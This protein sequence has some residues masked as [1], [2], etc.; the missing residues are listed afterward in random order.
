MAEIEKRIPGDAPDQQTDQWPEEWMGEPDSE[1]MACLWE[2]EDRAYRI[3]ILGTGPGFMAI[4]DIAH[5]PIFRTY[6]PDLEVAAVAEPGPNRSKL[7]YA[8]SQGLP[9]YAHLSEML[10]EHRDINLL[11]DLTGHRHRLRL[12]REELPYSVSFIDQDAAIFLCGLHDMAKSTGY[13]RDSLDRQRHLLQ[14]IIDEVREDILLLDMQGRVVDMNR[15]VWER[16]GRPKEEL[17]GKVCHE[18][19]TLPDGELLCPGGEESCPRFACIASGRKEEQLITRVSE[20]G[21]LLY[22]RVYAYPIYNQTGK[23]THV[24]IMH[25]DITARTMREK[26]QQQTDKLAVVGEMSTYLA[27][28]IRNPLMAIGGF[29]QS[30]MKSQ[31]LTDREREKLSIIA[32]ETRRLDNLLTGILNFV[33]PSRAPAGA[34]D[35]AKLVDE[36]VDLMK[37]GYA[38]QGYTFDVSVEPELPKVKG[39]EE[40]VKQCLVNMIKN[41]MEAMEEGG[42]VKV[43][44]GL[45]HDLVYL[46]VE[47]SGVGMT[48]ADMDKVFSPFYS[49][50]DKGY[51]LGLAMMKK[52]VEDLGGH[53]DLTSKLGEGT[54]VTI[55]LP[56]LLAGEEGQ[57]MPEVDAAGIGSEQEHG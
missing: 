38:K 54:T 19:L 17:V 57:A 27:H 21:R 22:F 40:M 41:S 52:I 56:P 16:T 53:I 26:H 33:R 12:L 4:M 36:T 39:G 18:V 2:G 45:E 34:V 43:S 11:I 51:G 32:D 3:G 31:C 37:A 20:D 29:T 30:L 46:R 35:L 42:A 50:K 44:A 15:H 48:D 14:A 55:Y 1:K 9:I 13:F 5:N 47:D 24:M 8:K 7:I 10:G 25:R 28:E 6:L 49:T 23:Q